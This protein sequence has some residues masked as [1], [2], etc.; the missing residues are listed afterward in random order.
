MS[1]VIK[2]EPT[3][4]ESIPTI[5]GQHV[6]IDR[7]SGDVTVHVPAQASRIAELEEAL[8]MAENR[9]EGLL[10][11]Q[12]IIGRLHELMDMVGI[13]QCAGATCCD[14]ECKSQIE[15]RVRE[16]IKRYPRVDPTQTPAERSQ[17]EV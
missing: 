3:D 15:H 16:Y 4:P 11:Y 5:P 13:P 8:A 17:D 14:P 2:Y 9:A 7:I 6:V 10:A 12:G 1:P